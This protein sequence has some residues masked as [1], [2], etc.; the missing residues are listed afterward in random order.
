MTY[1]LIAAFSFWFVELTRLPFKLMSWLCDKGWVKKYYMG[2][3][4]PRRITPFD[5][6]LCLA[7]WLALAYALATNPA[8]LIYAPLTSMLA[9]TI[10]LFTNRYLR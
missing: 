4:I 1:V 2:Q 7:F 6:T 8:N 5:C 9:V 3:P 10:S